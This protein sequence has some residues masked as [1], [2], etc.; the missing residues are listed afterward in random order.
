MEKGKVKPRIYYIDNLRIFLTALVVL[1]HFAI[2]YGGPGS[3]FY[4][5]S[6]AEFPEIIPLAMFLSTNQAFFMGMFF[7]I[8]AYFIVPSL[9]R[10]GVQ[11]FS[12]DR[13]IR[14]GIPTLLFYFILFP[15][16]VFIRNKYINGEEVSLLDY[17]FQYKIFGFGPMWFVEA[18]LIF[19]FIYLFF[20]KV[21]KKNKAVSPIVFP[22]TAKLILLACLIGVGQFI[23]RIWLPVGWEMPLTSF[24]LPHFLQYIILFAL[25]AVAY[26]QKW[27]EHISV[28]MGWRWFAWVQSLVFVGFPVLFIL[29]GAAENGHEEFMGG[30]G[31]RN[32][33]YAIWEQLVGIGMIVALFGI[34]KSK[35]NAQGTVAKKLSASAY[36]VYVFHAPIIVWVS[37]VFLD[38]DI[39]QIWK[40]VV[41]APVALLVCF[42][43][44]YLIKNLPGFK[45][46]F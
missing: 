22:G 12:K 16:T 30:L 11:A 15:L 21:I 13:L 3:W 41:L 8:S 6:Q 38:F 43:C 1:H 17:I 7:F 14:L 34:F 23:I 40:F 19:T 10:K 4:N 36:S 35:L 5:E 32:F 28:K 18:L 39:P 33:S 2:T 27:L 9:K 45:N 26:E 42:A 46:I 44:G 37:F 29:G 20:K 24:Q 31:W 25:G